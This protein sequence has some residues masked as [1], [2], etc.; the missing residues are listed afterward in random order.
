[1]PA[2][3][4]VTTRNA[5]RAMMD[6][7]G[8]HAILDVRDYGQEAK[9]TYYLKY[10]QVRTEEGD[11]AAAE[12]LQMA[13]G[14]LD[15]WEFNEQAARTY[16]PMFPFGIEGRSAEDLRNW[17]PFRDDEEEE[18]EAEA[19]AEP[20]PEPEQGEPKGKG[21]GK[22]E[23]CGNQGDNG[24]CTGRKH[25]KISVSC[26]I[27]TDNPQPDSVFAYAP[28]SPAYAPTSPAYSPTSP[29]YSPTSPAYAATS[30]YE[31]R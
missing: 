30:S 24:Q 11:A 23:R 13:K 9:R 16:V 18:A 6:K 19:E 3:S 15:R 5:Q 2:T 29:A 25:L 1:M 4:S 20:E 10:Q 22:R 17:T 28:T 21:K 14:E 26:A 31:V 27:Q 8:R 7:M 12:F